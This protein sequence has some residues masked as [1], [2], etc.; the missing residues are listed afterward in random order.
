M[1]DYEL[2]EEEQEI[3]DAFDAGK[4]KRVKNFAEEKLKL[5]QAAANTLKKDARINIRITSAVLSAIQN[6]A[7]KEG[8]PYQTLIASILHKYADG[9]FIEKKHLNI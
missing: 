1:K 3:L 9:Q 6:L 8:M 4:L 2:D 5:Q 7:L